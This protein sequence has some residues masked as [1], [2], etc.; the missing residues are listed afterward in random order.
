MLAGALTIVPACGT[1]PPPP[2]L[3][4][5]PGLGGG[6]AQSGPPDGSVLAFT[7]KPTPPP[8]CGV[9]PTGGVCDCVDQPLLTDVPTMYFILDRSGSMNE[10]NKWPTITTVL[11]ATVTRIGPRSNF[12]LALFPDPTAGNETCNAGVEVMPV[13]PGDPSNTQGRTY[14]ILDEE[15]KIHAPGGGTPTASTLSALLPELRALPGRTFAILA[16]DGGPNCNPSLS[17]SIDQCIANIEGSV[18]TACAPNVAPNCCDRTGVA[19]PINCLDGA[20][21]IA[22]VTEY[23]AAGIPVYVLGVPGSG[24]YAA[25]LDQLATAGGTAR[26]SEPLYY[27]VD[28]PDETAFTSALSQI[29]A[30]ITASCTLTL[31]APPSD[32]TLVNVYLDE[33]AVPPDPTNGWLLQDATVTLLG[34]TCQSVLSGQSLDVRV[35]EGCPTIPLK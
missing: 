1:P 30:K 6:G 26:A 4:D 23:K 32:P 22:M 8:G 17:C 13:R 34:A 28:T 16:T 20:A 10:S 3:G 31:K 35:I 14:S 27:S 2:S 15:L 25:L 11:G 29:A 7:T 9:G 33:V 12:G 18:N 5:E 24:P 19:G 21:T